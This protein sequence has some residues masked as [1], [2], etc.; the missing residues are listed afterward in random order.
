M[1]EPRKDHLIYRDKEGAVRQ[2]SKETWLIFMTHDSLRSTLTMLVEGLAEKE[3]R[4]FVSLLQE[5]DR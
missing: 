1:W 4:Q 3:A 5:N 2:C